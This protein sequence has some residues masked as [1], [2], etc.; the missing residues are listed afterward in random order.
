LRNADNS[1]LLAKPEQERAKSDEQAHQRQHGPLAARGVGDESRRSVASSPASP[2]AV[3]RMPISSG[4]VAFGQK[5]TEK[6]TEA[7]AD[8]RNEK[9]VRH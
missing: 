6:R 9:L 4:P 1:A 2:P 8:I 7:I 3:I 5:N